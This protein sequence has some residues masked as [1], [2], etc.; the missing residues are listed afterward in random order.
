MRTLIFFLLLCL[1][2]SI[3]CQNADTDYLVTIHTSHGDIKL[4]LYDS[5][6]VHKKNFLKLA[7][8]KSYDSTIFHRVINEFMIQGGG[9]KASG[10]SIV[11]P[12]STLAA[13]FY[14]PYFHRKGAVAAA[15]TNNPEKRSSAS[16]FYIVQGTT[17][18]DPRVLTVD[19]IALRRGMQQFFTDST[20]QDKLSKLD[21]LREAASR[22]D[23]QDYIYSLVPEIEE[24]LGISLSK[25]IPKERIE[26]YTTVGGAPH[27]DDE[28]TVFGQVVEGLEVIDKI[29]AV[30]TN[31][32]DKPIEDVK[33]QMEVEEVS[34]EELRKRYD[35]D[36]KMRLKSL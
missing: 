31:S 17:I 18:E 3:G 23:Y 34:S 6:S 21:S 16:Q 25:D 2:F 20:N 7:K 28:Y 22:E 24:S 5:T 36:D 33:V 8:D 1:G 15:R 14:K 29:A 9:V 35:L 26:A 27:L 11:P 30:P 12:D 32:T 13:E 4:I 10:E 19:D